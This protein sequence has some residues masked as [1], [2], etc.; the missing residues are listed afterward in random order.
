M[1]LRDRQEMVIIRDRPPLFDDIDR[2]FN[3]R[4]KSVIFAWGKKIYVPSG[5]LQISDAI[6]E[7]E[8]VHGARQLAYSVPGA[9]RLLFTPEELICLWWRRYLVDIDFRRE[10]ESLAHV[11]ELRHLCATAGGRNERRRHLSIVASKLSNPLYGPLMNKSE[12][13]KVLED[14]NSTHP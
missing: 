8:R 6:I 4:G 3:V 5:S 7:H 14:G 1:T 11:A 12:A 9:T 13:R 2:V 10:E